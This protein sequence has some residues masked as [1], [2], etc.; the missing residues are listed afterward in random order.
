MCLFKPKLIKAYDMVE[1]TVEKE[2]YSECGIHKGAIGC[3]MDDKAVRGDIEVDF[4]WIDEDGNY[5]GECLSANI[6]DLR[7]VKKSP[8]ETMK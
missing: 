1:L 8:V 6:N 7:V 4:S 2:R 5:C 3:V